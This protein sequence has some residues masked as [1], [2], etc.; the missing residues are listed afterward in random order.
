VLGLIPK[1]FMEMVTRE[2]GEDLALEIKIRSGCKTDLEFR[3]N[4]VYDDEV[5]RKIVAAGC[6]VLGCSPE[7]LEEEYARYFLRDALNRWPPWFRMSGSAREFLERIR[8]FITI[9][10]RPC[11][12]LSPVILLRINFAL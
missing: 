9:S 5:W 4:E 8:L 2:H 6:E 10:R 12:I 7:T 11:A 1:V 3:I